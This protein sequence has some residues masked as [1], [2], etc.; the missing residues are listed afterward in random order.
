MLTRKLT[1]SPW[2][3]AA[4]RRRIAHGER[5]NFLVNIT[6]IHPRLESATN[7]RAKVRLGI[8]ANHEHDAPKPRPG[9]AACSQSVERGILDDKFT[10]RPDRLH[11]FETA[12]AAAH[13][14]SEDDEI[15]GCLSH[16]THETHESFAGKPDVQGAIQRIWRTAT[17]AQNILLDFRGKCGSFRVR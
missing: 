5:V 6:D 15:I 8:L 12:E 11:L 1:R 7:A 2:L 10:I 3:E 9:L 4:G 16:T 14:R 13:A 17:R